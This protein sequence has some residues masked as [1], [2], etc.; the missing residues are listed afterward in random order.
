MIRFFAYALCSALLLSAPAFAGGG[1]GG[2]GGGGSAKPGD[3]ASTDLPLYNSVEEATQALMA[4]FGE[5]ETCPRNV[6][7]PSIVVPIESSHY[8]YGYAFVTPRICLARGVSQTRFIERLHF[9]V[10]VMVRSAHRHPFHI[11]EAG[12]IDRENTREVLLAALGDVV[13]PA[14]IERLDLLG[15]DVRPMN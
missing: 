12:E 9:M 11:N 15:S 4:E 1:G 14:Q 13:D 5:D 7:V 3:V 2:G 10:D 8:L 6:D